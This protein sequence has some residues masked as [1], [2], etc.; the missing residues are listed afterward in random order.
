MADDGTQQQGDEP[1]RETPGGV[2]GA[3]A[4]MRA[5]AREQARI[6]AI[7]PMAPPRLLFRV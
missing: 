6:A 1:R 3:R 5:Q 7:R 4:F 2:A